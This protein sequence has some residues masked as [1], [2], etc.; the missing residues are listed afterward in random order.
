MSRRLRRFLHQ[1]RAR[2][3]IGCPT[4]VRGVCAEQNKKISRHDTKDIAGCI[5]VGHTKLMPAHKSLMVVPKEC[6][7]VPYARPFV[8]PRAYIRTANQYTPLN[9]RN[10]TQRI[11]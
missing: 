3:A 1:I 5:R 8:I 11:P 6:Q 4:I 2:I 9:P 7:I 10:T